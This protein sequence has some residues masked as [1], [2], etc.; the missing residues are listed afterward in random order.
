MDEC[1]SGWVE[2]ESAAGW[3]GGSG[4]RAWDPCVQHGRRGSGPRVQ[5]WCPFPCPPGTPPMPQPGPAWSERTSPLRRQ[6]SP[7]TEAPATPRPWGGRGAWEQL[8]PQDVARRGWGV[9]ATTLLTPHLELGL[10]RVRP[11]QKHVQERTARG[12]GA[13]RVPLGSGFQ[14]RLRPPPAGSEFPAVVGGGG[15]AW[16]AGSESRA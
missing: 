10:R 13:A 8:R 2:G 5:R 7:S 4:A 15:A 14:R 12:L 9:A 3:T 6:T 11:G 1:V 16:G